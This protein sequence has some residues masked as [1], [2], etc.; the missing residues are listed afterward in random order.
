MQHRYRHITASL[1]QQFYCVLLFCQLFYT[2]PPQE[3]IEP[4]TSRFHRKMPHHPITSFLIRYHSLSCKFAAN[5][6]TEILLCMMGGEIDQKKPHLP[7][8]I[9]FV[10]MLLRGNRVVFINP[11]ILVV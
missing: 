6:Q 8:I 2:F 11:I 1:V 10:W 4:E 5:P 9:T 7:L 3:P